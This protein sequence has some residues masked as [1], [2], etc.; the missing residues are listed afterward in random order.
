MS[1]R[2]WI[3]LMLAA[4]CLLLL[5][6]VRFPMTSASAEVTQVANGGLSDEP[7]AF[8]LDRQNVRGILGSAVRSATNEDMGRVVD[9]IVDRGGTARAAVIDFGG[10]LGVGSRKIAVDWNAMRFAGLDYVMLDMTRDQVK[11]APSYEP[12][13]KPIVVLRASPT[14]TQ[15]QFIARTPEP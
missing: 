7:L 3:G 8:T 1:K 5:L 6:A 14:F 9:I 12:N 2:P 4:C 11:A 15:S 10:F 13:G